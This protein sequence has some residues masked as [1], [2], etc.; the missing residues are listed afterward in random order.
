MKETIKIE[1]MKCMHCVA[2]VKGALEEIDGVSGVEVI[3]EDGIAFVDYDADCTNS[4]IL[5]NAIEDQGFD[6]V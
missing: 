3:L 2:A 4:A 1:G 5:K 6:V